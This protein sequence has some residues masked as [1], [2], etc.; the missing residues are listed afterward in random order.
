[1]SLS[2]QEI[3]QERDDYKEATADV[4]TWMRSWLDAAIKSHERAKPED[5]AFW[6][7]IADNRRT[8]IRQVENIEARHSPRRIA[9]LLRDT[10]PQK[11]ALV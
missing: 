2:V 10:D 6:A 11:E 3:T 4:L 1:M 7:S 8:A 5:K 9:T